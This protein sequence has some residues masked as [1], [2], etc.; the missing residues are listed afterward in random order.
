M[1]PP[2]PLIFLGGG[3]ESAEVYL[4]KIR[5]DIDSLVALL[6]EVIAVSEKQA[7]SAEKFTQTLLVVSVIILL[8][9]AG[10]AFM[11]TVD[12]I[13]YI[14]LRITE[15]IRVIEKDARRLQ[16]GELNYSIEVDTDNEVGQLA[17]SLTDSIGEAERLCQ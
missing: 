11:G 16:Q 5:P 15:P 2:E 14:K 6:D 17:A 3:Q 10:I 1:K 8:V 9:L 7:A 4:E 12:A 13:K